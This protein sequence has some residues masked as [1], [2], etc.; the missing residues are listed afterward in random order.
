MHYSGLFRRFVSPDS[1]SHITRLS[2]SCVIT[3][4]LELID[5]L[6][7]LDSLRE[8]Y[9]RDINTEAAPDF[10]LSRTFIDVLHPDEVFAYL[11]SLEVLSYEG[12]LVVQAIDFLE[13]LLIRSRMREGNARADGNLE[14][15]AV[16]KK[17]KDPGGPRVEFGRVQYSRVP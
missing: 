2:L 17:K 6:S 10:G 11:P 5:V 14:R 4:E 3:K 1:E 8:L 9:V 12:N 13:P 16:L 15:I 7:A